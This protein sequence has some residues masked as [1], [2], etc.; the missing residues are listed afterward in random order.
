MF[1]APRCDHAVSARFFAY[2]I[3]SDRMWGRQCTSIDHM[4]ADSCTGPGFSMGDKPS[5]HAINLR[6]IFRMP[7]NEELPYGIGPF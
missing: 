2:T 4:S 1:L 7:T 5:N 3:N 6:G